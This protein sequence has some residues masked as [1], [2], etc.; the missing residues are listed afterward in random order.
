M[1][2]LFYVLTITAVLMILIAGTGV[3]LSSKIVMAQAKE[4]A[5]LSSAK[6]AVQTLSD[7]IKLLES[8]LD[9]MAQDPEVIAAITSANLG[10]LN[11]MATRL[12]KYF[13]AAGK[14]RLLPVGTIEPD[15]VNVPHMGYG[16]LDMVK[17][18]FQD[19]PLPAIQGDVGPDRH[20]A[21]T[22]RVVQGNQTVGV[23]LASLGFDFINQSLQ[24]AAIANGYMELRQE[25]L[26]LASAGEKNE[27]EDDFNKINVPGTSWELHYRDP[28]G[29]S[30]GQSIVIFGFII[31]PALLTLAVFFIGYRQFSVTLD[32]D[33]D[34]IFQ[35]FKMS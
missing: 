16:D 34:W 6:G 32:Q 30:L 3:Y 23:I 22:R 20:L 11:S 25:K 21:I 26:A 24:D 1:E 12:E 5:A 14:I 35:A 15:Q 29:G 31:I 10:S 18:T 27:S 7:Q 13:P 17:A 4:A 28:N 33:L 2:R 19:N 9:R 8:S